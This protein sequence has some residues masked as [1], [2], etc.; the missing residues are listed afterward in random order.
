MANEQTTKGPCAP[1]DLVEPSQSEIILDA[2]REAW[3]YGWQA[4]VDALLDMK[5][6]TD[7][8]QLACVIQQ[9]ADTLQDLK[10]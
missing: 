4:C 3:G 5:G 7:N 8:E 10:P 1:T 6:E 2:V 9:L